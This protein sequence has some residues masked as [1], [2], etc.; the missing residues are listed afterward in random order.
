[1][2]KKVGI[3]LIEILVAITVVSLAF[4]PLTGLLTSSNRM[5]NV[6]IYEEMAVHY[7]RELADQLLMLC[8]RFPALV[9]EAR[10]KTGDTS[11]DLSTILNDND[12]A[13]KIT[14]PASSTMTIPLEVKGNQ[15][16][17]T[18]MLSPLDNSFLLRQISID[19]MNAASNKVF[20]KARFWKATIELVWLDRTGGTDLMR[21]ITMVVF[22]RED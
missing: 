11:L 14:R 4:I 5:S 10:E 8:P 9:A 2:K 7:A 1:M 21:D 19:P 16:A 18:L 6:S 17:A 20:C 15:L 13:N 3:S 22:L 12:F